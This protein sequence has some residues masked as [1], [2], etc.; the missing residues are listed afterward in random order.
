MKR[1]FKGF[2]VVFLLFSYVLGVKSP[3]AAASGNAVLIDVNKTYTGQLK[4]DKSN[5][6][7]FTLLKDGNVSL[8][9]KN[10]A[11]VQWKAS[12]LHGN[13]ETINETYSDNSGLVEGYETIEAGLPKGT[14]YIEIADIYNTNQQKYE[15]KLNFKESSLY[16]KEFNDSVASANP[17]ALNQSYNGIMQYSDDNDFYKVSLPS[18]GNVTLYV[19]QKENVQW[20]AHIQNKQGTVYQEFYTSNSELV[21][22]FA[23]AEV[24]LP[25]GDYYIKISNSHNSSDVPYEVKVGFVKSSS[26]E[27]E[28]ND[29]LSSANSMNLNQ[30]YKGTMSTHSDRDVYKIVLPSDGNVTLNVKQKPNVSWD[31]QILN[32]EGFVYQR[33][34][35]SNDELVEGDASAQVGLPKGTYYINIQHYYNTADTVYEIKAGFT[36]SPYYEKEKNN[37]LSAANSVVLNQVYRGTLVDSNDLDV[38]KFSIPADGNIVLSMKQTPFAQWEG[39]IQNGNTIVGEELYTDDGE[40][41]SGF[42]N[43]QIYLKKGTYYYVLKNYHAAYGKPYEFKISMKSTDLKTAQIKV[44]NNTGKSDTVSV[45]GIAKGDIVKVY[46]ASSKGSLLGQVTSAGTSATVSIK[47]LGSKSGK[48]YVSVTKPGMTESNRTAASFNGEISTALKTSQVKVTNNKGKADIVA[49][50]GL[51]KGDIVKVYNASS[52]GTL[53][54]QATS[55]GSNV[56]VSIKQLGV[57]KGNVYV[58]VTKSGMSESGRTAVSFLGE[59]SD[60]PKASNIKVVNNKNKAD[61]VTVSGVSKGSVIKVYNAASKGTLLGSK[62]SSGSSAVVSIKQLGKKSGKVYVSVTQTEQ[63]ESS[64]T[65]ASYKAE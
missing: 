27:K 2:I 37:T 36:A 48:V 1:M 23:T 7:K 39:V 51:A 30:Y 38:F 11:N 60:A 29:S 14:Y 55:S 15:F 61:T 20:Q 26:Y 10:K 46:N 64:R 54:G 6:Y 43:H 33:V 65:A 28:F 21:E 19:K 52:K 16:E 9:F 34:E 3:E 31:A 58:T 35:T 59:V 50:S 25:K 5:Y 41:A 53:L 32:S 22:G 62:T 45:S 8:S 40:L 49:V 12:I 42:A 4:D 57:K 17:I 47:Q 63:Q 56:S 24:G 13:G 18:D 44:T